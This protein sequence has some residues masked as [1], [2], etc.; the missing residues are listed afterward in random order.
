MANLQVQACLMGVGSVLLR[1]NWPHRGIRARL[2]V[3]VLDGP[4]IQGFALQ[5]MRKR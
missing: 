5:P 4:C 3:N 2:D 1:H